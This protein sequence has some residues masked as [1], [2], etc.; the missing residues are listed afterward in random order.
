MPAEQAQALLG[1]R[2]GIEGQLK[3]LATEKDDTFLVTCGDG[4]RYVAKLSNPDEDAGEISLEVDAIEHIATSDPDLP[5]PRVIRTLDGAQWFEHPDVHGQ[6]RKVRLLSYM[7]GSLMQNFSLG[8][9]QLEMVGKTAAKLRLAL[10]DFAHP[11]ADRVQPWDIKQLPKISHLLDAVE[12]PEKEA[13]RTCI[14]RFLGIEGEL[15]ACRQQVLHNDFTTSNVLV[16]PAQ[17]DLIAGIIDFGDVVRT[18]IVADLA[19]A[20]LSQLPP[21]GNADMLDD[22]RDFL[23]GYLAVADLTETELR[24]LPHLIAARLC[25]RIL[26]TT[27]RAKQF[28]DNAPYILRNQSGAFSRLNYFLSRSVEQVDRLFL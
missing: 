21:S 23:R 13:V 7:S 5:V 28:P 14:D 2:Y 27:W 20:L 22:A 3:R 25:T 17:P 19:V 1:A 8:S 26:I 16:D 18:Y 4:Q 9:D 6:V 24:L 15:A 11:C 12:A 10:A